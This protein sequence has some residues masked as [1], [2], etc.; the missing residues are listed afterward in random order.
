MNTERELL[1][2]LCHF[3][4]TKQLVQGDRDSILDMCQRYKSPPFTIAFPVAMRM[5]V[6]DSYQLNELMKLAHAA[7]SE[8]E[9]VPE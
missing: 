1:A 5:S 4:S 8:T 2:R 3:I 9:H 6:S 7:L